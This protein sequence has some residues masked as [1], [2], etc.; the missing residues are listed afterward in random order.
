MLKYEE[1]KEKPR[2][3]LAAIGLTDEE[4]QCLLPAFENCYEQ[5]SAK[6]PRRTKKK[7]Q[8]GAGGGRKSKFVGLTQV[9]F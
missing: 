9:A 6:K 2:E 3:F 7:K 4:F 5:L 8:R 1:L